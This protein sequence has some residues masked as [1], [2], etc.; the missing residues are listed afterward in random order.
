MTGVYK[1]HNTTSDKFYIGSAVNISKRQSVH[2][3][4]LNRGN[5]P[6]KYLQNAWSKYGADIFSFSVIEETTIDLL[7]ER[8][9]Y[10]LD[11]LEPFG[12]TGYNICKVAYSCLGIKRSDETKQ[13]MSESKLGEKNPMFGKPVSIETRKKL[14]DAKSANKH[15]SYGK[16]RSEETLVKIRKATSG[17]VITN[18]TKKL[19][20]S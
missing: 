5:H 3:N 17:K 2:T 18:E 16:S 12:D 1:I 14:S 7:I 8:E 6:N 15:W 10:Y 20:I 11:L 4:L 13:R 9:Q 19:S